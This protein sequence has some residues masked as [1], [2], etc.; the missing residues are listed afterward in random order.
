[1]MIVDLI[2]SILGVEE[3][4]YSIAEV[5]QEIMKLLLGIEPVPLGEC[6]IIVADVLEDL[7]VEVVAD[8]RD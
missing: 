2:E 3:G 4:K 1:M 5:G 6:C 7:L 8:W